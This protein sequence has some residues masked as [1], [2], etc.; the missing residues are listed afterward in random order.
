MI[1]TFPSARLGH[2]Q[3]SR[4]T[5]LLWHSATKFSSSEKSLPTFQYIFQFVFL[6]SRESSFFSSPTYSFLHLKISLLALIP[7]PQ[8]SE[9]FYSTFCEVPNYSSETISAFL[10]HSQPLGGYYSILDDG[11]KCMREICL[12][13]CPIP[14]LQ[15]SSTLYLRKTS[16]ISGINQFSKLVLMPL[17]GTVPLHIW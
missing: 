1:R 4:N 14:S 12:I 13:S 3:V 16:H 17:F 9:G 5:V 15:Q 2:W 10:P 8:P 11:L 6:V 7:D